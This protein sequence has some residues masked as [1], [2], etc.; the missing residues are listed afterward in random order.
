MKVELVQKGRQWQIGKQI[1][2]LKYP[3]TALLQFCVSAASTVGAYSVDR[4][5]QILV[6]GLEKFEATPA[7]VELAAQLYN[8]GK[9]LLALQPPVSLKPNLLP[10]WQDGIVKNALPVILPALIASVSNVK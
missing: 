3:P 9:D 6:A 5:D 7:L 8:N 1:I 10:S 2:T 4:R